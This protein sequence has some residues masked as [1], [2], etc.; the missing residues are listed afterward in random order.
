[1]KKFYGRIKE[2]EALEQIEKKFTCL[3][4]LYDYGRK[5]PDWQNF[6]VKEIYRRQKRLLSVYFPHFGAIVV[7]A[8]AGAA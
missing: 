8:V 7:Q 2:I 6:V 5:A 4:K 3:C 1:M